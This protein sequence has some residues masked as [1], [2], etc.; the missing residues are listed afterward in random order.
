MHIF[1]LNSNNLSLADFGKYL[2]PN[3]DDLSILNLFSINSVLNTKRHSNSVV[4]HFGCLL[5]WPCSKNTRSTSSV[6]PLWCGWNWTGSFQWNS[7]PG[8]LCCVA[9][10]IRSSKSDDGSKSFKL[11]LLARCARL[12]STCTAH[13]CTG[14]V[15]ADWCCNITVVCGECRW[16]S[17]SSWLGGA[18]F[19]VARWKYICF[20]LQLKLSLQ[21]HS[22]TAL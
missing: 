22:S 16:E 17:V 7:F 19:K 4:A 6:L 2:Q 1:D 21:K 18:G 8:C 12:C 15:G 9:A 5:T 11:T 20:S 10:P 13:Q 14:E 3:S